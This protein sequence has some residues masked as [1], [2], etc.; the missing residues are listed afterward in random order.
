MGKRKYETPVTRYGKLREEYNER[1][2]KTLSQN[3]LAKKFH[4]SKS[5]ISRI[6]NGITTPSPDILKEYSKF[7]DVSIEYLTDFSSA[8]KPENSIVGHELGITDD[9]VETLKFIK[10]L[11]T[12]GNNY[13]AVLNAFI[14]NKEQTYNFISTILLYLAAE[15]ENIDANNQHIQT[16]DALLISNIAS[17][18]QNF[19]KPQLEPV[20]KK[21]SE[22]S[23]ELANIPIEIKL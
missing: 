14:N 18:I 20:L 16:N 7:F 23:Q 11:S 13:T 5:S 6:E 17:Y 3:D 15:Y 21:Y 22:T 9:V 19:V 12:E 4:T 8:K 10:T 1:N 2:N